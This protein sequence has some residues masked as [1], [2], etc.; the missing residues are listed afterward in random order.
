VRCTLFSPVLKSKH[1]TVKF[2]AKSDMFLAFILP[3]VAKYSTTL[4]VYY[5]QTAKNKPN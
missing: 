4:S 3:M 5:P 2:A 1:A